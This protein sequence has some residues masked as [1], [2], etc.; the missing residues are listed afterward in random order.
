MSGYLLKN[1][2]E[3]YQDK[4]IFIINDN[5]VKTGLKDVMLISELKIAKADFKA[6]K[7]KTLCLGIDFPRV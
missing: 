7:S 1:L 6:S 3:N 4:G 2:L 5:G